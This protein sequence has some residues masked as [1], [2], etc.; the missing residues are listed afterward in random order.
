MGQ[1]ITLEQFC[2]GPDRVLRDGS[3]GCST[4]AHLIFKGTGIFSYDNMQNYFWSLA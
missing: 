3:L 2:G 1:M 4:A